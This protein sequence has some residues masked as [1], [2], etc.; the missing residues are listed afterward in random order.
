MVLF[1]I[2]G[3]VLQS[4]KVTQYFSHVMWRMALGDNAANN[5][6]GKKYGHIMDTTFQMNSS[7]TTLNG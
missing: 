1:I 6:S 3:T 4:Q 5:A 2:D 7:N